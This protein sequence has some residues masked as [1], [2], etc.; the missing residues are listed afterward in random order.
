MLARCSFSVT[1]PCCTCLFS[2]SLLSVQPASGGSQFP[3]YSPRQVQGGRGTR[4]RLC[5]SKS[6]DPWEGC[7]NQSGGLSPSASCSCDY[8]QCTGA[9]HAHMS[10]CLW[11]FLSHSEGTELQLSQWLTKPELSVLWI[12][13]KDCWLLM[14]CW[15][16][17]ILSPGCRV[18]SR[19]GK[20][21]SSDPLGLT[22]GY[23]GLT[24]MSSVPE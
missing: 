21:H 13:R 24:G 22:V 5:L 17:C 12:L 7:A 16:L 9:S 19:K 14:W 15:G 23:R 8:R 18:N 1:G 11:L 6:C 10:Q 2:Q 3:P 4:K 20:D